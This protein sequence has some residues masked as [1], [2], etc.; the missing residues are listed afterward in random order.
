MNDLQEWVIATLLLVGI[1]VMFM[2]G[3]VL[4]IGLA[5]VGACIIAA[6]V[7]A[8]LIV[9]G[10]RGLLSFLPEQSDG[11]KGEEDSNDETFI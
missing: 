1:M 8:D 10:F 9:A 3:G 2:F 5:G 11:R 6:C 7:A 4:L